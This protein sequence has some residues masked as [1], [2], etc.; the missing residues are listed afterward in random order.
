LVVKVGSSIAAAV[1]LLAAAHVAL[2]YFAQ[3]D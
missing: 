1:E 2:D 3:A